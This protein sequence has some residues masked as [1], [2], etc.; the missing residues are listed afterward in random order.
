MK[1]IEKKSF[2]SI[3]TAVACFFVVVVFEL[4]AKELD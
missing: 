3:I 1:K 2:F 4:D